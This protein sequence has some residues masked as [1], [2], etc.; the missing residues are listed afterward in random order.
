MRYR[1]SRDVLGQAK[2]ITISQSG[3]KW[4]A[5]IQTER[6]VSQPVP[7]VTTAI[8]VD[9]GVARFAIMSDGSFIAPLNSFK[10]H[11]QRL[12]R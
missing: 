9:V 5:S 4:Y 7:T 2:N 6:E 1:N 10:K 12:A 3:G 11:Q 8:G